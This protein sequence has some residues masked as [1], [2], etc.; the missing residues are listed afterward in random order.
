MS[1]VLEGNT[2]SLANEDV[3]AF[4]AEEQAKCSESQKGAGLSEEYAELWCQCMIEA[5][6]SKHGA[7][8]YLSVMKDES[9]FSDFALK[10]Q[11]AVLLDIKGPQSLPQE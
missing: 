4:K 11:N 10:C 2:E 9:R 1:S 7:A 8:E 6:I 3:G 5:V